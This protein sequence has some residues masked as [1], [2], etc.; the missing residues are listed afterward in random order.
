MTNSNDLNNFKSF[1]DFASE[2]FL[3]KNHMTKELGVSKWGFKWYLAYDNKQGWHA[4]RLWLIGRALRLISKGNLYKATTLKVVH[5]Q[6]LNETSKS[7][8]LGLCRTRINTFWQK[9]YPT[10]ENPVVPPQKQPPITPGKQATPPTKSDPTLQSIPPINSSSTPAPSAQLPTSPPVTQPPISSPIPPTSPSL[11]SPKRSIK[12]PSDYMPPEPIIVTKSQEI[13]KLDRENAIKRMNEYTEKEIIA[14]LK[15]IKS[16]LENLIEENDSYFKEQCEKGCAWSEVL[17][18][19]IKTEKFQKWSKELFATES[20]NK[21]LTKI[22]TANALPADLIT[23]AG[24]PLDEL[25]KDSGEKNYFL[26]RTWSSFI[27][28]FTFMVACLCQPED[29]TKRIKEIMSAANEKMKKEEGRVGLT[30]DLGIAYEYVLLM[31]EL[32]ENGSGLS[33]LDTLKCIEKWIPTK[34]KQTDVV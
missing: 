19:V 34:P 9:K 18:T 15:F 4:N 13:R 2:W 14:D 25:N 10:T 24:Y 11:S 21:L 5:D 26:K 27:E 31:G 22:E 28:M 33:K 23:K 7:T 12:D 6:L 3:A 16:K 32:L 20:L 8:Y 29:S 17:C 30:S 1:N